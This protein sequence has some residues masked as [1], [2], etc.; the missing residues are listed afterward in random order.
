MRRQK[1]KREDN[2]AKA[3]NGILL[4]EVR[5]KWL[6]FMLLFFPLNCISLY[7]HWV[8]KRGLMSLMISIKFLVAKKT[9]NFVKYN[10]YKTEPIFL[11]ILFPI[12]CFRISPSTFFIH[13]I[14]LS[15]FRLI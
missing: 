5:S 11:K 2:T 14:P 7:L 4:K 8:P 9:I 13:T 15:A 10:E 6:S 3:I 1:K 12:E